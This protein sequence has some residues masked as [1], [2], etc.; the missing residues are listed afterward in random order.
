MRLYWLIPYRLLMLPL[1]F[2]IIGLGIPVII[3]YSM[4]M[5]DFTPDPDILCRLVGRILL[6]RD[7]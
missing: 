3:A 6:Y 7:P 5:E 4:V 2:L 1:C